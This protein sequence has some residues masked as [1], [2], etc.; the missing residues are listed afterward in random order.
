[1]KIINKLVFRS[2]IK[3]LEQ[4][5]QLVRSFKQD[6]SNP[7]SETVSEYEDLGWAI[8][9]DGSAEWLFIGKEDPPAGFKVGA[10]I[11]VTLEVPE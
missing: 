5:K 2:K 4:K 7:S 10:P 3:K 9:I 11:T 8:L 6:P 1:M